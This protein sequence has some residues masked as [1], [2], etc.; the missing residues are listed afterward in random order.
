M[1]SLNDEWNKNKTHHASS[2][3]NLSTK[4]KNEKISSNKANIRCSFFIF[5]FVLLFRFSASCVLLEPFC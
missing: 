4:K 5:I 3:N 1:G 2:N